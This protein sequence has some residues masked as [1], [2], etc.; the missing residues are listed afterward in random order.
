MKIKMHLFDVNAAFKELIF[1]YFF[2]FATTEHHFVTALENQICSQTVSNCMFFLC[3]STTHF[4]LFALPKYK[5]L[6]ALNKQNNHVE[7]EVRLTFKP[8]LVS[9]VVTVL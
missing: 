4:T 1:Y 9:L 3:L 2:F 5:L 6:H 7:N 8:K